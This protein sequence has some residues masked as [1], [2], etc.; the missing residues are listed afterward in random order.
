MKTKARP[1][2]SKEN[3]AVQDCKPSQHNARLEA[4]ETPKSAKQQIMHRIEASGD[5]TSL[6]QP[7]AKLPHRTC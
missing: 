1:N 6:I 7:H 3:A 4:R 5:K 2:K